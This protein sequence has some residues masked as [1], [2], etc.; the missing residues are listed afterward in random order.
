M[1]TAGAIT[2]SGNLTVAGTTTLTAGTGNNITLDNANN[3]STVVIT[4]GNNVTLNDTNALDLGAST[5][6]GTFTLTAGGSITQS[7]ALNVTG[8]TTVSLTTPGTDILLATQAN[9]QGVNAPVFAGTLANFRDVAFR[10]VNAGAQVPVIFPATTNLA[11]LTNL[12]NLTLI[13]DNAP[14]NLPGINASGTMTIT[15]GGAITDSGPSVVPGSTF[16]NANG[17]NITLDVPGNNFGTVNL[18]GANITLTNVSL[19]NL[20][21]VQATG[22]FTLSSPGSL[23]VSSAVSSGSAVSLVSTG[24]SLL[25]NAP[26]SA[27]GNLDL[28]A[29]QN[30]TATAPGTL[31][32]SGG[33]IT[34]QATGSVQLSGVTTGG[35]SV[36]VTAGS[37]ASFISPL[38][39]S[40][41]FLMTAPGNVTFAQG[42]SGGGSLT[43]NSA[44]ITLFSGPISGLSSLLTDAGGST[45]LGGGGLGVSGSFR[46]ND[47]V[48]L[49]AATVITGPTGRFNGTLNGAQALTVNLTGDAIFIGAV[50]GAQPLASIIT[51]TTGAMRF[52]G[53]VVATTGNQVYNDPVLLG[54]NTVFTAANLTFSNALNTESALT[55][56]SPLTGNAGIS[57]AS[58]GQSDLTA[59]VTGETIFNA[60]VGQ[61]ADSQRIGDI[62]TD[63]A[64][65]TII[66]ANINATKMT[67]RDAVVVASAGALTLDASAA[68]TLDG[69]SFEQGLTGAGKTI[70]LHAPNATI[71]SAGDIGS[72]NGRFTAVSASGRNLIIGG[73][74]WAEGDILLSIGT[75]N[76]TASNDFL[77]FTVPGST[78]TTPRNTRLDSATGQIVLGTGAVAGAPK[79]ETPLRSSLFK[80]DPG[81]LYLFA[82]KVTVQ[83]FERLA[84]RNGSLIIIADGTTATDGGITLGDA[85]ASDYLIL[86]GSIS[87]AVNFT[88]RSRAGAPVLDSNGSATTDSG[89]LLAGGAVQFYSAGSNAPTRANF[90]PGTGAGFF[91][92]TTIRGNIAVN[93]APAFYT[94]LPDGTGLHTVF[95]GDLV[96]TNRFRTS[97]PNVAFLD[98]ITAPGIGVTADG[99]I[100]EDIF[101]DIPSLRDLPL[102]GVGVV[103]A[104][105]RNNLQGAFA[106]TVP[107]ND[108]TISPPDA[109]LAAAVR[110][111]L[112]AIGIYARALTP[113]E[114][115]ARDQWA[116]VFVT[117]PARV[118]PPESDYQVADARVEDRAVRE[119]IRLA[120]QIGLIGTDQSGLDEV[121]RAL[122]ASYEAYA[123]ASPTEGKSADVIVTDF[124]GWLLAN[125]TPDAVKVL[126]YISALRAALRKIELLGLTQKEL[127]GSK[128]QIYGSVLRTRL[129]V[130]P[131]FLQ[132]LVEG[133]PAE[134]LWDVKKLP[135]DKANTQASVAPETRK[136][137]PAIN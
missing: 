35:G 121:A 42:I 25:L 131:E 54:V 23:T 81:G 19:V 85:A 75:N 94:V 50:G 46:F 40:G 86:V 129:N 12:R 11:G 53:G 64:G 134:D 62:T 33:N 26:V 78:A 116:A 65:R 52:H 5:V 107:R 21:G 76:S 122:A 87:S 110:E 93:V 59:N 128:A 71:S 6:S 70:V 90:A 100:P 133:M 115:R 68:S 47:P 14:I 83:P 66:R 13:F 92:Y 56:T 2:D 44:G 112:Q 38:A 34:V 99:F 95:I 51:A 120:S 124:R 20:A 4:S 32:S 57:A 89:A 136:A 108:Q 113:E 101:G 1:T 119:V 48:T 36:T 67:F 88:F 39:I 106:P 103:T 18:V 104:V 8:T 41:P 111:Q 102:R 135:A 126:D 132:A 80:S 7:G 82:K 79:T 91:D 49:A 63:A 137:E 73:D 109:D 127:A 16:L 118:R 125:R 105:T 10:N 97:L 123:Q 3:F 117:V 30:V 74:L 60:P 84:V 96:T 98:L 45:T 69:I 27:G 31:A 55:S 9:N 43:V 28:T 130:E 61:G 17:F 29:G 37:T 24:G 58:T 22:S 72:S 114:K 77:S 15:A